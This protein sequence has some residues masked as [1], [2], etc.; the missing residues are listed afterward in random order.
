MAPHSSI[1]AWTNPMDCSLPWGHLCPWGHKETNT[2]EHTHTLCE[3]LGRRPLKFVPGFLQAAPRPPPPVPFSSADF[4]L[5]PSIAI[6]HSHE[7]VCYVLC[8]LLGNQ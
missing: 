6:N 8:V 7:Y 1:L 4:V 5:C 3:L 2:A